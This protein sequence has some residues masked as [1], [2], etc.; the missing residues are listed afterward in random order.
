MEAIENTSVNHWPA[1]RWRVLATTS[2]TSSIRELSRP[3]ALIGSHRACEIRI[4]G[5]NVP[6]LAYFACC[7]EESIEAWPLCP[8]AFPEW[9]T[10]NPGRI[11]LVGHDRIRFM[12]ESNPGWDALQSVASDRSKTIELF[13]AT[14]NFAKNPPRPAQ[15]ELAFDW[16]GKPHARTMNRRVLILGSEHPSTLRLRKVGLAACDQALVGVG[17]TLWRVRLSLSEDDKDCG[18]LAQK[19][20]LGDP[21][22]RIGKML[23]S[24]RPNEKTK[25]AAYAKKPNIEQDR[26]TDTEAGENDN[27][28]P[29]GD[30]PNE[31]AEYADRQ[32]GHLEDNRSNDH[33]NDRNGPAFSIRSA[34]NKPSEKERHPVKQKPKP[35][36]ELEPEKLTSDLTDRLMSIDQSKLHRRWGAR[37]ALIAIAFLLSATLLTWIIW[38]LIL[39][40]VLDMTQYGT[41]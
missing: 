32:H 5:R 20:T 23:L 34:E 40:T 3:Y 21:P 24:I 33:T 31:V 29:V 12:H 28:S 19:M 38:R 7:F 1:A 11:L 41:N 6:P 9:G 22:L 15:L 4:R 17:E 25:E 30:Q 18:S 8:I 13:D 39:P 36:L 14:H 37:I 2:T 35:E 26:D 27:G 16:S 10:M